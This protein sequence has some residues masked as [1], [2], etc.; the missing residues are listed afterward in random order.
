MLKGATQQ[1]Q[2]LSLEGL[3]ARP[4]LA[5]AWEPGWQGVPYTDTELSPGENRDS[6]CLEQVNSVA[7]AEHLLSLKSQHM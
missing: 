3:L 1:A 4:P 6:Q 7:Q 2:L 5:G